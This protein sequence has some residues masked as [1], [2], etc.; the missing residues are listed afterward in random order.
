MASL[1]ADSTKSAKNLAKQIARQMAREPLEVLKTA[2]H[3]VG[4]A[5]TGGPPQASPGASSPKEPS[6][7]DKARIEA[8]GQRQLAALQA[9]IKEIQRRKQQEEIAKKQEEKALIAQQAQG[10]KKEL[11]TV[12]SKRSRRFFGFGQKA[13]AERQKTRVEKPLPP[14]G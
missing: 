11:P 7:Q 9:E 6:V 14:S 13:Q 8:Q 4:G 3:Q 2:G 12:P 1:A 5:E 10:Q